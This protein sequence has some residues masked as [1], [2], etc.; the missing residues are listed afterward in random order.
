MTTIF[1][2]LDLADDLIFESRLEI[3]SV[4]ASLAVFGLVTWMILRVLRK[5]TAIL[6]VPGR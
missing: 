2:A 3:D 5:T 6:H 1:F 4:W